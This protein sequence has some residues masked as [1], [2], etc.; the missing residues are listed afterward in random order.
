M[1]LPPLDIRN[2]IELSVVKTNVSFLKHLFCWYERK[3]FFYFLYKRIVYQN[4][5]LTNDKKG[6]QEMF[7]SYGSSL[8]LSVINLAPMT[9][10][11]RFLAYYLVLLEII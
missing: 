2:D 5:I 1:K 3:E 4:Q 7:N 10:I 8:A 11:N 6:L 9:M